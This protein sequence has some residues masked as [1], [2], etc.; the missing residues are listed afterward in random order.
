MLHP[1]DD[2]V[3]GGEQLVERFTPQRGGGQGVGEIGRQP[4]FGDHQR[5][6]GSALFS[7]PQNVQHLGGHPECVTDRGRRIPD[8]MLHHI[9]GRL[10]LRL[11][12]IVHV[13]ADRGRLVG[14][15]ALPDERSD[16]LPTFDVTLLGE[17]RQRPAHRNARH[18]ELI[19]E[20]L[21][22]GQR[23][24]GSDSAAGDLVVQHQE[25]LTMQRHAGIRVHRSHRAAGLSREDQYFTPLLPNKPIFVMSI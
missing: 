7:H 10:E 3:G 21:L 18:P 25:K 16:A 4:G 15:A 2:D 6:V 23:I 17:V 14:S 22:G 20:G 9:D 19:A 8:V 1:V 5:L 24:A 11:P 13:G 12:K